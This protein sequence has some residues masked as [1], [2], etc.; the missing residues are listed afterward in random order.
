MVLGDV[1][2]WHLVFY[3]VL[4]LFRLLSIFCLGHILLWRNVCVMVLLG[5]LFFRV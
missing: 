3:L 4:M 2:V 5:F 1:L